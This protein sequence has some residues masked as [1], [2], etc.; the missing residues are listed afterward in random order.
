MTKLPRLSDTL[1]AML[2]DADPGAPGLRLEEVRLRLP[3]EL[4]ARRDAGTLQLNS[5]PTDQHYRTSFMPVLHQ[6]RVN[7][8]YSDATPQEE[9]PGD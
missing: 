9:D 2:E 7:I 6:F 3:M 8:R 4:S 1:A 5:A